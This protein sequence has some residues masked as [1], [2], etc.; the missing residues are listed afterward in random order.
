MNSFTI[1]NNHLEIYRGYKFCL[2]KLWLHHY[3]SVDGLSLQQLKKISSLF[4]HLHGLTFFLMFFL[5]SKEQKRVVFI[6][7]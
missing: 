1:L 4:G 3:V 7:D 5:K 2:Q 6:V